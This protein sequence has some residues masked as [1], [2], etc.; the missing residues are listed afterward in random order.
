MRIT[1]KYNLHLFI[2]GGNDYAYITYEQSKTVVNLM[3]YADGKGHWV[4]VEDG[5]GGYDVRIRRHKVWK[6][7]TEREAKLIEDALSTIMCESALGDWDSYKHNY[8][9]TVLEEI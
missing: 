3:D 2:L 6:D 9:R 1:K 5:E 7:V 8:Y 4:E